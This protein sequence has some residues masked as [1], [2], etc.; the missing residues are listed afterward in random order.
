MQH[1]DIA[2]PDTG[3]RY[4][5]KRYRSEKVADEEGGWR[6][7]RVVLQP[8]SDQ[9][10]HAPIVLELGPEQDEVQVVAEWLMLMP[11]GGDG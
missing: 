5:I 4:T 7:Q 2:D 6:H 3:G 11:A 1:R 8:E 9:P 10:G